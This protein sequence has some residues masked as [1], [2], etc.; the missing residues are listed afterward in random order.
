M[1]IIGLTN[2][3]LARIVR[4]FDVDVSAFPEASAC[5]TGTHMM[6]N[7]FLTFLNWAESHNYHNPNSATVDLFVSF[8]P[9][10]AT[11]QTE[12]YQFIK[13]FC[14]VNHTDKIEDDMDVPENAEMACHLQNLWLLENGEIDKWTTMS[15]LENVKWG[16]YW[17]NMIQKLPEC[18]IAE[19]LAL[20]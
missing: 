18:E 15:E 10:V 12:N 3:D 16:Q 13:K 1:N 4:A 9:R 11:S 8:F 17:H 7:A 20:N 14:L 6:Q 19:W 2:F 5:V